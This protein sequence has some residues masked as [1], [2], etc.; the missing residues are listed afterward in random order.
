[1]S[2][3]KKI[4]TS[5]FTCPHCGFIA[6]SELGSQRHGQSCTRSVY[7]PA[8]GDI[9]DPLMLINEM[10]GDKN[11]IFAS[12]PTWWPRGVGKNNGAGCVFR[13]GRWLPLKGFRM[14]ISTGKR[15]RVWAFWPMCGDK[16]APSVLREERLSLEVIS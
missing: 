14:E 13:G 1:M 4:S 2:Q 16:P 7:Q 5:S 9:T 3:R 8:D 6:E 12:L 15:V 11:D 10:A